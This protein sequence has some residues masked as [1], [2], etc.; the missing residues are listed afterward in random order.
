MIQTDVQKPTELWLTVSKQRAEDILEK[1]LRQR[2]VVDAPTK[3]KVWLKDLRKYHLLQDAA[4]PGEIEF[5]H[6]LFQEYYA[7]EY[8]KIELERH[9][10]WLQKQSGEPYTYFQH[11]YLNYLKW[12]ECV[13]LMLALVE[14]E[15]LAV[16]VVKLALDVDLMLG[17]RLA[18]KMKSDSQSIKP[19]L[20][21]EFRVPN[22]IQIEVKSY[23]VAFDSG[24]IFAHMGQDLS[25]QNLSWQDTSPQELLSL[26]VNPDASYDD[27]WEVANALGLI[28]SDVTI[29]ALIKFL[30]NSNP[31]VRWRAAVALGQ[32]GCSEKNVISELTK[33]LED[34]CDDVRRFVAGSLGKIGSC[35]E[36]S[37]LVNLLVDSSFNVRLEAISALGEIGSDIAISALIDLLKDPDI[38]IREQIMVALG[39]I[40]SA[41]AIPGLLKLIEGGKSQWESSENNNPDYKES[42]P[43]SRNPLFNPN[44]L[45]FMPAQSEDDLTMMAAD[46]IRKIA[47]RDVGKA[48]FYLT[49]L[50]RIIPGSSGE[51]AHF[52]ILSI[53]SNCKF[54]NYEIEQQAKLRKADR[55]SLEGDRGDPSLPATITYNV[56][57][58][59]LVSEQQP[60][61]NQQGA[62]IGVNYAAANSNPRI[63]QNIQQESQDTSLLAI[64]QIIQALEKK[65]TFVQ[66]PQQ[67]IDIIDAEFKSL[68]ASRSPQW[69]DLLNVKRLYNGGKKA[70]AKVGEHFAQENVWGKGAVAFLEGISEDL[71]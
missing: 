61:F 22:W 25:W 27:I 58:L 16:Q 10:E 71:N 4:K 26:V 44:F 57:E 18:E 69:Q 60:I 54:Y 8:L 5:H 67:A 46:A 14:D 63:I 33:L 51:V 36:V 42:Q 21:D 48:S 55:P 56:K 17:A 23:Q 13:A 30:S 15:G 28:G 2:E 12:T 7:A 32:I 43:F 68:E 6:Q 31:D 50:Q 37:A 34:S 66:E 9:P 70:A 24:Q 20:M 39:Q 47:R 62:T 45:F 11:F 53:Q 3:A 59:T 49:E 19:K 41:T 52:V 40:G 1:W 35:I 64:V 29:P 38:R 65:Y